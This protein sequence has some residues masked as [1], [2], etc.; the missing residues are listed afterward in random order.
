MASGRMRNIE[1][2]FQPKAIAV[3]GATN[4]RHHVGQIVTRNLLAG[5]FD[6]PIMPVNPKHRSVGGVL[7]YPTVESVPVT[8][9]LA[10]VC[11]PP[12]TVPNIVSSLGR[13]GTR[14]AI[15][16]SG[17]FESSKPE[18]PGS[19]Y[20]TVLA[21]ARPYGIRILGTDSLGVL[22]PAT[23][24]N[25][26]F[27]HTTALPGGV[28]FISQS[29]A[30][31]AAVL[32]GAQARGIGFSHFVSLGKSIDVD[33]GDVMDYLAQDARTRAI[34]LYIEE[35]NERRNFLSVG[36]AA[37]RNKPVLVVKANRFE[38][39]QDAATP[40]ST[41]GALVAPDE[42]FD[43]AL[44]RAGMLR[45]DD[46]DELFA[47]FET[48]ARARPIR[49]DRLMVLTNG[50]GTGTMA[51]DTLLT[52]HGRLAK[53]SPSSTAALDSLLGAGWSKRNPVD[54]RL[55]ASGASY[56]SALQILKNDS[57]ADAVLV[58]HA[59]NLLVRPE[60]PAEAV[61]RVVKG[62]RWPC[63]DQLDRPFYRC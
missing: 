44:R 49:G 8:P 12:A 58:T 32:D 51:V 61:I 6:G 30:L 34:L 55:D 15:I 7:A 47:A 46:V 40:Q 42:V 53:L 22:V 48:L 5:G 63:T 41:S 11:T 38:D 28:A 19:M 29:G 60:E 14:A 25:A 43:A 39:E 2:L 13:R 52:G 45:V 26:S 37:A 18:G 23:G 9:D 62:S 35:I 17:G 33:F 56:G 16:L 1:S 59:P 31:C 36:R 57:A 24:L 4:R 27:A 3:V 10:V 20:E 54:L 21:A 50:G